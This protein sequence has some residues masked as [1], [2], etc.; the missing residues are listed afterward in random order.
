M[1]PTASRKGWSD[2]PVS[3]SGEEEAESSTL[4]GSLPVTQVSSV[5][6]SVLEVRAVHRSLGEG[7]GEAVRWEQRPILG[8]GV[9]VFI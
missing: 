7:R 3:L 5:K 1:W 2:A 6:G 9:T 8:I 4:G